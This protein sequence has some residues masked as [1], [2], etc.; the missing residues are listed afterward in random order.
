MKV[1]NVLALDNASTKAGTV[2]DVYSVEELA[3]T[4]MY[5]TTSVCEPFTR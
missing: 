3:N 4:K 5:P 1:R 2:F